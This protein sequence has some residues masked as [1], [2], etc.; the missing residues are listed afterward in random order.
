MRN[1]GTVLNGSVAWCAEI[2]VGTIHV[3]ATDEAGFH[4]AREVAHA[5][6]G[7]MLR[8]SGAPNDDGYAQTSPA[9]TFPASGWSIPASYDH[10]TSGERAA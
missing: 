2:G 8:E 5:H 10:A 9:A 7:W 1:V 4:H 6:G 3:A